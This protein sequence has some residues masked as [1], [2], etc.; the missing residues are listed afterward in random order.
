M[1]TCICVCSDARASPL[2]LDLLLLDEPT[3]HLDLEGVLWLSRQLS[4]GIGDTMVLM[5]SHDAAFLDAVATDIIH[6]RLRQLTYYQGNYTAYMKVNEAQ[7]RI[8]LTATADDMVL[9]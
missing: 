4:E 3:N 2:R 7:S 6:F 8:Y 5:V 1:C 9:L